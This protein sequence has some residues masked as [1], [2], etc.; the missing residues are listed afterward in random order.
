M[1]T[2]LLALLLSMAAAAFA[3]EPSRGGDYELGGSVFRTDS[4]DLLGLGGATLDVGS[5]SGYSFWGGYNFGPHFSLLGDMS[6][7]RPSYRATRVIAATGETQTIRAKLDMSIVHVKGVYNFLSG[8]LTP[9][10]ELG[11]GWTYLDSNLLTG[12][13]ST[14]CWFD[15]WWGYVCARFYDTYTET[16]PSYEGGFGVQWDISSG[17][18]LRASYER[19]RIDASESTPNAD[20]RVLRIGLAWRF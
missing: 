2:T 3:Q 20:I 8:P 12:A 16:R 5:A 10:V 14:G 18:L 17:E 1:R 19:M 15:P 13:V 9:F 4:I 6:Y 11:A 7:A